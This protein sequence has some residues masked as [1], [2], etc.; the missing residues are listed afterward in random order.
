MGRTARLGQTGRR[1]HA[2]RDRSVHGHR[3]R[4]DFARQRSRCR[5]R[6]GGCEA[7]L[8][9]YSE[10]TIAQRID[11]LQ[12]I[13]DVYRKRYD[14]MVH[15][16]SREM[17]APL[18]YANDAQAWTGV[19]HLETMIRTLDTFEFEYVKSS[20]LI[21]KEAV[22]VCGLITPWNWPAL[23]IATKV[24]PALAAGCTMVLK[25]SEL[26]PLSGIIFAEILDEAGVP[27]GVFNLVNGEG[28][29]WARRCRVIR[30]ST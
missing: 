7:C 4:A 20:I 14:D 2:R 29:R 18:Q 26:A 21:R 3:V 30:T 24:V 27:A 5:S 25:P 23:Q 13:L 17:G 16:I 22:G 19:A 6:R 10:T 11:L 28:A 1:C 12:A 9:A 15:A 8:S